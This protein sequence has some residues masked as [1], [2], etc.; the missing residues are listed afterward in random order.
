[1]R[2]NL[3]GDATKSY[4]M[5][6]QFD[7]C[8]QGCQFGFFEARFSNSAGFFLNTSGFF[9]TKKKPDKIWLILACF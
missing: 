3:D 7:I 8:R 6:T 1:M 5:N 2:N 9:G 4:R